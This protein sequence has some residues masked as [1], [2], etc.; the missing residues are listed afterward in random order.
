MTTPRTWLTRTR[1][2]AGIS[3]APVVRSCHL[4]AFAAFAALSISGA[5]QAQ[6]TIG[7]TIT[8]ASLTPVT[9]KI[10]VAAV[11]ATPSVTPYDTL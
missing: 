9:E 4:A 2:P 7:A 10:A 6:I 5:V 1:G 8:G 3:A 11:V